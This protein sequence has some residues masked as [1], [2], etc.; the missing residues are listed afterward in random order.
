M[1]SQTSLT[2]YFISTTQ[3]RMASEFRLLMQW[4]VNSAGRWKRRKKP[5]IHEEVRF[6]AAASTGRDLARTVRGSNGQSLV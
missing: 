1:S 6:L 3:D 2:H 5:L 4:K